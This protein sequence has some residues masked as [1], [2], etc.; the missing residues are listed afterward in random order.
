MTT[1]LERAFSHLE[2]MH[3]ILAMH[4]CECCS[5]CA[6][7]LLS[8]ELLIQPHLRGYAFYHGQ[9][10]DSARGE[11][12]VG[13]HCSNP[14]VPFLLLFDRRFG[15]PANPG[16]QPTTLPVASH[17]DDGELYIRFAARSDAAQDTAAVGQTVADTLRS[18]SLEVRRGVASCP[19]FCAVL[20]GH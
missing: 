18:C 13:Q 19:F 16:R 6:H 12:W 17:A 14:V 8:E 4:D 2:I 1:K 15:R 10:L 3:D 5:T 9:D 11:C 7:A 20:V